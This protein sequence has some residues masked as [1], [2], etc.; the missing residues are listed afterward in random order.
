MRDLRAAFQARG[1]SPDSAQVRVGVRPTPAP[2]RDVADFDA[3]LPML[4][5]LH[6]AGIRTFEFLPT[7]WC[8]E[9]A[10]FGPF[11]KRILAWKDS[12]R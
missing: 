7:G 10:E 9:P 5:A 8:R 3:T 2:G 4:Q 6:A 1:R 11:L 12:V